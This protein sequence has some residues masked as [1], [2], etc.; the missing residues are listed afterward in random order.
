MAIVIN[1]SGTLSGLAVG[2]LPDGTVDSGTLATD[3]VVTGKIADGAIVN[4]DINSSAAIAGSKLSGV[5]KV[6]QIVATT[7]TAQNSS[8]NTNLTAYSDIGLSVDITPLSSSSRF[9]ITCTI[10]RGAITAGGG[11]NTWGGILF[12]DSTKIG[13][14]A[15]ISSRDG[16]FFVGVKNWNGDNNH[17]GGAVGNSYWNTTTGTAGTQLTFKV[18]GVTEGSTMYIN[19]SANFS[20]GSQ[21]Y[22]AT[23]SSTITV[24]EV[25]A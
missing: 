9:L 20:D 7:T 13:N 4:A 16:A 15:D 1:G 14:G 21:P 18:G 5:G 8:T 6:L 17:G 23:T 25:E 10:G 11:H 19:R 3:S 2:G 22:N 24:M 12:R